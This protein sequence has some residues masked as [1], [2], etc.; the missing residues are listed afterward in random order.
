MTLPVRPAIAAVL[1]FAAA[2]AMPATAGATP[3]M[4]FSQAAG[5]ATS[6]PVGGAV[7]DVTLRTGHRAVLAFEDRPGRR[8]AT[9]AEHKFVGLWRGAF[10]TDAPNAVLTGRDAQGRNRRVV[11][12]ITRAAR[13]ADGVRYRMRALRGTIPASITQANLL[14]D[15]IP[16]SAMLAYR[17]YVNSGPM[18]YESIINA[19]TFPQEV[20]VTTQPTLTVPPGT[21]ATFGTT[22]GPPVTLA[23][24]SVNVAS[25]ATLVLNGVVLITAQNM[26]L[27]P[28]ARIVMPQSPDMVMLRL[29][30]PAMCAPPPAFAWTATVTPPQPWP[31]PAIS[32]NTNWGSCSVV[33]NFPTMH[34]GMS[35]QQ[36]IEVSGSGFSASPAFLTVH[37]R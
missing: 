23:F 25:G 4:L 14:V 35:T 7:A 9:L 26:S 2:V 10:R 28:G 30:G 34:A 19:V 24:Q 37:S 5:M 13:T 29:Q 27:A 21:T 31:G 22:A 11:A 18:Q 36:V 1:L 33:W 20:T 15:D 17:A 16:L 8:T 6:R 12:V 32:T 3:S